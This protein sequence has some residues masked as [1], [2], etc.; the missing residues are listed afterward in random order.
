MQG[1]TIS[2]MFTIAELCSYVGHVILPEYFIY[3]TILEKS[4]HNSKLQ[5]L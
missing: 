5:L 3:M 4:A 2:F 1:Y